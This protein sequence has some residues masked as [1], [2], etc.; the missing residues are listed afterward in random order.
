MSPSAPKVIGPGEVGPDIQRWEKRLVD[1]E[2]E[3]LS[4][5][6]AAAE[7]WA[8]TLGTLLGLAGT[9][10][11]VRGADEIGDLSDGT[12]LAIGLLLLLA[13][14]AAVTATIL[15]AYAAQG[16]PKDLAW[17]TAAT[18]REWEHEQ[19]KKAK[20]LLFH[21]RWI[22]LVAVLAI[23]VAVAVAWLGKAAESSGSTVLFTPAAGNPLCGSLVNTDAGLALEIGDEQ[24]ALPAGPYD[25]TISVDSCPAEEKDSDGSSP[26]G[27]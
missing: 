24:V 10:L 27:E 13:F 1:L 6:R 3:E 9:V 15:T 8:A 19:A 7:K 16:T 23:A 21:S 17:P 22:T 25:N 2:T 20:G 14:A 26:D 18:L 12:K 5:V 11:I 4:K